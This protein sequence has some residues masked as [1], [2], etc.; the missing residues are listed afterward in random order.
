MWLAR[1]HGKTVA[2]KKLKLQSLPD[3]VHKAFHEELDVMSRLRHPNI[4][5]FM[6]ACLEPG[7]LMMVMDYKPRGSLGQ[8]LH[9]SLPLSL[10]LRMRMCRDIA[11]GMAWLHAH[12]PAPIIHR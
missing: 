4:L 7:N 11:A 5:L 8:L 1:L 9:S 2:A 3:D 10:D 12:K 6:G